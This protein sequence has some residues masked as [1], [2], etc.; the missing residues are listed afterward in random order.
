MKNELEQT[1]GEEM[2]LSYFNDY[3]FQK[4]VISEIERNKMRNLIRR[5]GSNERT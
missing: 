2:W 3:L 5:R 4:Q 1:I